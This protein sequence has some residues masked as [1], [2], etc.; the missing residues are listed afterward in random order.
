MDFA[1]HGQRVGLR[2]YLHSVKHPQ[3]QSL[4]LPLFFAGSSAAGAVELLLSLEID[5]V[6]ELV[7][8][9][10]IVSLRILPLQRWIYDDLR[11]GHLNL[12]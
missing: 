8:L 1:V 2:G 7:L 3:Q 11:T 6:A 4:W 12:G 5:D 9:A 10:P